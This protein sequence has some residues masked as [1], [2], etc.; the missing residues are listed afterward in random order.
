MKRWLQKQIC[1]WFG[2]RWDGDYNPRCTRCPYAIKRKARPRHV[3]M[4]WGR[5]GY[6]DA[7]DTGEVW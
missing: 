6:V 7:E 2:H 3:H 1:A 4:G 5:Y